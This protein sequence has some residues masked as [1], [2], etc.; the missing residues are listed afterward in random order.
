MISL[1]IE[2]IIGGRIKRVGRGYVNRKNLFPL[3]SSSN[4]KIT[5]YLNYES[6]FNGFFQET[7]YLE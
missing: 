1:V 4:I 2:N 5:K 7:I 3:H 6:R